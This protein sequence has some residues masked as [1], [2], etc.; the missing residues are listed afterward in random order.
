MFT[1]P[2]EFPSWL[3]SSLADPLTKQQS[4]I[5][6]FQIRDGVL[7]ARV[8]LKNTYGYSEWAEG[9][10]EYESLVSNDRN[11]LE[12]YQRE[13]SFDR[14]TYEHFQLRGRVLDCGGGAGTVREFL[15]LETEFVSIDPWLYAPMASGPARKEAYTCLRR[16]LNFI[17]AT[18]EFIP[19]VAETFD[20]VHMR[21]M[22]DHVQVADLAIIEAMRVLKPGGYL[23]VGLY[24]EGG[25]SG[26]IPLSRRIKDG[27]KD[28]LALCGI[29]RWKDHH[30]WH[31]TY[32]ALIKLI[33]DNGFVVEDT[34]WQHGFEDCVCYV[35]A[36][37]PS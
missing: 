7:D 34:F 30:V 5:G 19:F 24:V 14:P 29:E 15:P 10:D 17:A 28:L 32:P 12:D 9:Q 4:S 8:F 23:L 13:I 11:T 33:S 6:D 35:Q 26:V 22:L 27:V 3:I 1:R 37:K 2:E 31:P 25:N 18:A 21:S 20:W 36:L 16:P